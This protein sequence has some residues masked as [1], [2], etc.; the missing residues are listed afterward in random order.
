[1]KKIP[2]LFMLMLATGVVAQSPQN[3]VERI[4]DDE[5]CG[6]ELFFVDGIQT[7]QR[8]GL[9]GFK[10]EDGTDIVEPQYMFVD[11][12]HGP[13]CIVLRDYNR[14]GL[15]DRTG[16]EII[17]CQYEEVNYP[18]DDL[19]RI[20]KNERYG[21][22]DLYGN[23]VIPPQYR[24]ASAFA[25]GLAVVAID[26]DSFSVGY[27]Y[28]NTQGDTVIPARFEYCYPFQNGYAVVK[29]YD[30]YGLIDRQG[31]EVFPIKY[32]F[33]TSVDSNQVFFIVDPATEKIVMYSTKNFRPLTK[34][35]YDDITSYGDGYYA[36][37]RG[38]KVG[39]LNT[40]GRERLGV[41]DEAQGFYNGFCPVVRSGKW[42]IINTKGK[43]ILPCDYDNSGYRGEAYLFYDGLAL[44]EKDG[45]YGFVDTK[46]HIVIPLQYQSAYRFVD[47]L[48]PAKKHD[49]WGFIDHQGNTAIP[50]VFDI[51]SFFEYGRAEVIYKGETYKIDTEGRC[52][53]NCKSA[54]RQWK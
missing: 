28:I 52:V 44:I 46:G 1:M 39:F 24:A 30:R 41:Y 51:A 12:F 16:R 18:T 42:G 13:Y 4:V 8:N 9:F 49:L 45:R 2:F 26:F 53:K 25:E 37:R 22:A 47:G 3:Q 29:Q 11:K 21:F 32:E 14:Q 33:I 10:L 23:E 20:M 38:D 50:F 5:E 48:A 27:G 19:C 7:T 15:I 40:K 31:R 36:F 43:L 34:P 54:P 35:I 17:P 6:C